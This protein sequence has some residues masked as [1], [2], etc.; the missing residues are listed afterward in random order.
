MKLAAGAACLGSARAESSALSLFDGSTLDGWIQVENSTTLLAS[1]G[2]LDIPAFAARLAAGK[3]AVSVFLRDRLEDS[4]KTGL[5]SYSPSDPN[6]KALLSALV[7]DVN[8]VLSGPSI[9]DPARFKD[10]VLRPETDRL[11]KQNPRGQHLARLNK[12]LLEDAYP[13]ELARSVT[14]GWVVK[15]GA[16]AST[17]SGRGVI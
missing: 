4:V 7:K 6:A 15:D 17:G 2:I 3:D 13:L 12:L 1:A 9:Y 11:L 16:M 5:A 14:A 10:S 8:Q